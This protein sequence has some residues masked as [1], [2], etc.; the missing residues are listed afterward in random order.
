[1]RVPSISSRC[2]RASR[3]REQAVR[4]SA[5]REIFVFGEAEGATPFASLLEHG[6]DPPAVEIDPREDL[7]VLPYSSGTTGLPKGVMLTHYNLVANLLQAACALRVDDDG[8]DARPASLLSHLRHGR[9][10]EPRPARAARRSSRCRAS[11]SSSSCTSCRPTRVTF[12]SRRA[13]DR[14]RA[15]EAPGG[16]QR[17]RSRACAPSSRAPRRCARTWR[18]PPARGSAAAS[19]GLRADRDVTSHAR[20]AGWQREQQGRRHRSARPE[21]RGQGGGRRIRDGS[22]APTRRERSGFAVRR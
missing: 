8:H 3:R 11:R 9:D 6:A 12:A 1:M 16:G 18:T 17:T 2:R 13:A 19:P 10:H 20:D 15:G 21:H 7:V 22:S 14:A 4:G 5:V